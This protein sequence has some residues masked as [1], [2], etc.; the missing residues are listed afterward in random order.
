MRPRLVEAAVCLAPG[1]ISRVEIRRI[2]SGD[3]A[4][5][6]EVRLRALRADPASFGST[7]EREAAYNDERWEAWARAGAGGGDETTLL[8][9]DGAVPVGIVVGARREDDPRV[10]DVFAMWVAPEVRRSGVARELL[11]RV[12]A[13]M[14]SAGGRESRLSVTTE[15]QAARR[16][17]ERAGY[18][19]AG[20][21][22]ESRHTA[23]L[24][25]VGMRKRLPEFQPCP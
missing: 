25:E 6:R 24:V 10:F 5:L 9:L 11:A 17:Y 1:I 7:Y 15:A 13:W 18:E 8:A 22:Q 19:E 16:L 2:A 23:G 14:V 12:E 4:L 3:A 20:W 21:T